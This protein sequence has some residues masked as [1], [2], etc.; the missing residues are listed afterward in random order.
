MVAGPKI[1]AD[2]RPQW[3]HPQT[4]PHRAEPGPLPVTWPF[5]ADQARPK[6]KHSPQLSTPGQAVGS[7]N[8]HH[9]LPHSPRSHCRLPVAGVTTGSPTDDVNTTTGF[10]K[11][12]ITTLIGSSS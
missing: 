1:E 9:R 6:H 7:P 4:Q 11:D 12:S 8:R 10:P 2:S 5:I 3:L